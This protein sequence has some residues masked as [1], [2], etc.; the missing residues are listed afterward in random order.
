M[1]FHPRLCLSHVEYLILILLCVRKSP[2]GLRDDTLPKLNELD[3]L[4]LQ[5]AYGQTFK[6]VSVS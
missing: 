3:T 1:T 6:L 4:T 5:M 2:P